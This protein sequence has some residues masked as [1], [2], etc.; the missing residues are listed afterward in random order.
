MV[1][2]Y[3]VIIDDNIKVE[4]SFPK[5]YIHPFQKTYKNEK[6]IKSLSEGDIISNH[7]FLKNIKSNLL[8]S[9]SKY[10]NNFHQI[11]YSEKFWDIEIGY[12]LDIYVFSMFESWEMMSS[13]LNMES[14]FLIKVRKNSEKDLLVQTVDHLGI[15]FHTPGFRESIFF[16]IIKYRFSDNKKFSI[17]ETQNTSESL[18]IL[19][20]RD[21][22]KMNKKKMILKIY[23]L[24]FSK[25]IKRQKYSI[26][27][28]Y[29]SKREDL[30]LNFKL[31]QFPTFVP[32][33]YSICK[34]DYE[35]RK[36][37]TL[38][39]A[40]DNE[41]EN[42]LYKSIFSFIPVSFLEGFK[43][44]EK[45][46]NQL[47]LPKKPKKI[48]SSNM[49]NK[50]LLTRY[51][52]HNVEQGAKLVLATH[53]GCYGHYNIHGAEEHERKISSLYL[54]YGWKDKN[55]PKI[56]PLGMIRPLPKFD[57][58]K[59]KKLLTMILPSTPIFSNFID[60]RASEDKLL[61][62][63][64]CFRI[65]DNLNDKIR[66]NNL[67]IRINPSDAGM[68][69][70]IRFE[71]KYPNIKIDAQK[72]SYYETLSNTKIFLSPY[73]G[74]G[75]LETL[76]LNIPTIVTEFFRGKNFLREDAKEYYEILKEAKIYFDDQ[77]LLAEHINSIWDNHLDWWYS[78]KVQKAVNIFC[79]EFA[80][81]NKN[82]VSEIKKL[83]TNNYD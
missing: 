14:N 55:D 49:L 70:K 50:N 18:E 72:M 22:D 27:R 16:F 28:S 7:A 66:L 53:G 75:F 47:T 10:L 78:D 68:G 45:K 20:N 60:S 81:I 3:N 46:L 5:I 62:F 8:L 12:W 26:L 25:F 65:V 11:N 37:I 48:F 39:E 44:V 23:N 76:A 59:E 82:K 33:L 24:I 79:N 54:T 61:L 21:Y 74:T 57:K 9:T 71:N 64:H 56:K 32:N 52:A 63:Q 6:L 35:L 42:F 77:K 40:K 29:L 67:L 73:N 31:K 36:K 13:L 83:L 51:C 43:E 69:E 58:N 2:T 17:Y 4:N 38:L 80:Y 19:E 34:P 1:E 41:F 15:K 30:Q